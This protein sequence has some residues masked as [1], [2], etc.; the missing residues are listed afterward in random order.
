[1]QRYKFHTP[2]QEPS[3]SVA[4]YVS[5]LRSIVE[6][7]N[8]DSMLDAMLHDRL[9]CGIRDNTIQWRLLAESDLN[10]AKVFEAAQCMEAAAKNAK[11]LHQP[12][13]DSGTEAHKVKGEP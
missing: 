4:T 7:C 13:T 6:Y 2:F 1:M 12:N 3:E 8:F 11:E 10:F 9:V 5:E